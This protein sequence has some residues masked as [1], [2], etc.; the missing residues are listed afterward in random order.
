MIKV[1][2]TTYIIKPGTKTVWQQVEQETKVVNEDHY[3]NLVESAPFFRRLG[4]SE[5]LERGYTCAGYRVVRIV[6]KSPDRQTKIV[7]AI[8]FD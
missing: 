8:D 3:R 5:Y 4:G 1:T 2:K 6:S 7:R